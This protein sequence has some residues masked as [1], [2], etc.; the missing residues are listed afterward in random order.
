L[1]TNSPV[2]AIRPWEKRLFLTAMDTIGGSEQATPAQAMVR[3][4]SLLFP[5]IWPAQLTR[6]AGRG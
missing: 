5:S 1:T 6:T 4:F 3:R 2:E